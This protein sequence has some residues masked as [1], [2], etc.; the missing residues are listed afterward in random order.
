MSND[1]K[2]FKA[3]KQ[4]IEAF[5]ADLAA[6][7]AKHK[8]GL[9]EIKRLTL[10]QPTNEQREDKAGR[11]AASNVYHPHADGRFISSCGQITR[12]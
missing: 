6:V 4:K 10:I 2:E 12:V 8:P 7:F 3:R 5:K 9:H 11:C 1:E